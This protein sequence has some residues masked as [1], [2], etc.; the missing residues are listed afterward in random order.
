MHYIITYFFTRFFEYNCNFF[1]Y[2]KL[3]QIYTSFYYILK[4][5]LSL[6]EIYFVFSRLKDELNLEVKVND[7]M[8]ILCPHKS[9]FN[10][11]AQDSHNLYLE[12]YNVS[13]AHYKHC[14]V[15]GRFV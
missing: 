2:G 10:R 7:W 5:L 12:V 6:I 8:D 11:S 15:T 14:A 9:S 3:F 1:E 13:A 4:T